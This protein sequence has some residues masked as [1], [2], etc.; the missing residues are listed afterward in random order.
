[1][2][3]EPFVR[4][5]VSA[6]APTATCSHAAWKM[7]SDG[8]GA[9]VV[10][11]DNRPQGIITDRDIATRVVADRLDAEH[12]PVHEVMSMQPVTVSQ[13][14]ASIG[15]LLDVMCNK[16]VRRV[17]V[18]DAQGKTV[19]MV[20]FDDLFVAFARELNALAEVAEIA[21]TNAST[22]RLVRG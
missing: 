20:S 6:V 8:V 21:T 12:V 9:V 19:G 7:K 4:R 15:D 2:S 5:P 22:G 3:I 13:Q 17:V 1:M 16:G 18:V 11:Q 14:S 10:E